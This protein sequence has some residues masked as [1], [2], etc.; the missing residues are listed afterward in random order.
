MTSMSEDAD[1][2]LSRPRGAPGAEAAPFSTTAI[3]ANDIALHPLLQSTEALVSQILFAEDGEDD[4]AQA[5]AAEEEW[6][7]PAARPP[8]AGVPAPGT[9]GRSDALLLTKTVRRAMERQPGSGADAYEPALESQGLED[10]LAGSA[11]GAGAVRALF[12]V[13][14]GAARS[15]AKLGPT[16]PTSDGAGASLALQPRAPEPCMLTGEHLLEELAALRPDDPR[17]RVAETMGGPVLRPRWDFP[18]SVAGW[19]CSHNYQMGTGQYVAQGTPRMIGE[20]GRLGETLCDLACGADHCAAVDAAGRVFTWGLS[21]HGRLGLQPARDAATPVQVRALA[22]ER[23]VSVHCGMYTSACISEDLKV[24]TWGAGSKGQLGHVG[25]NDEWLPRLVAGLHGVLVV[26]VA[27]GFEHTV[28]L[29]AAGCVYTWG[30]GEQGQLGRGDKESCSAPRPMPLVLTSH[31]SPAPPPPTAGSPRPE[32]LQSP[33][34]EAP[35]EQARPG[36]AAPRAA[37]GEDGAKGRSAVRARAAGE[38]GGAGGVD[39]PT[40]STR[41]ASPGGKASGSSDAVEE[42]VAVRSG[43][44]F[45]AL[46]TSRGRVYT[47]GTSEYGALGLGGN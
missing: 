26:Q 38:V 46:L 6:R 39:A 1:S 17:Q 34:E 18:A 14:V 5:P 27:L 12:T 16:P 41:A 13:D 35:N 11:S 37:E 15:A 23:I 31:A 8:G 32:G 22:Q 4:N 28:A 25:H 2:D 43:A 3:G 47:W 7:S 40:N 24:F 33:A 21:D 20:L 19:G 10:V 42:V 29:D 44:F 36:A 9:P 45:S 30:S